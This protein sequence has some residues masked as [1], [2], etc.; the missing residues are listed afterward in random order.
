MFDAG[1]AQ[2]VRVPRTRASR[3]F[4]SVATAALALVVPL[5]L[6][7]VA[8]ASALTLSSTLNSKLGERVVVNAQGR[9]LYTLSGESKGH[10]L[11]KSSECLKFWPPVTVSS[12]KTKLKAAG[13]VHGRLGI[14]R[15]ANGLLQVTLRGLP[16]YRFSQ[17]HAKGEANGQGVESFGGTWHAVVAAGG[18]GSTPPTTPTTP[19]APPMNPPYSY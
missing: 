3:L 6:A 15:R 1:R 14:L 8:W 19:S 11:C 13:R 16:L 7:A 10:L 9:T 18:A 4:W 12:T 2:I 5:L 17:D